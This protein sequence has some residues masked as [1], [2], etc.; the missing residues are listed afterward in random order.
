ML[1]DS[2]KDMI[3]AG[4]EFIKQEIPVHEMLA[5]RTHFNVR[6]ISDFSNGL[7]LRRVHRNRSEI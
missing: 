3:D 4:G 7:Q 2:V 1:F 5:R 6:D